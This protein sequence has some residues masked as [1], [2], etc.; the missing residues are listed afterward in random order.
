MSLVRSSKLM[1]LA[2]YGLA[3]LSFGKLT[4]IALFVCACVWT[5]HVSARI[6]SDVRELRSSR[7]PM[8]RFAILAIWA[9]TLV[10]ILYA[11]GFVSTVV[12]RLGEL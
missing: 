12:G 8:A 9:L 6:K 4:Q 3:M 2:R 5:K 1:S 7:D 10:A 11:A